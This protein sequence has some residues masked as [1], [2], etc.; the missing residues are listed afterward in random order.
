MG[1]HMGGQASAVLTAPVTFLPV[2]L[3][4][5]DRGPGGDVLVVPIWSDVRPLRGAVGLLDWRLC[6]KISQMIREGRVSGA[7]GEK[8]LLVTGRVPWRRILGI[9]AGPSDVFGDGACRA[10]LGCAFD[11][12]HGIGAERV[13][14]AL[15]GRDLD[16]LKPDLAMRHLIES[17]ANS[18]AKGK[19]LRELTVIDVPVATKAMSEIARASTPE[20]GTDDIVIDWATDSQS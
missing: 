13:A 3:H 1:G 8:L 6:G 12:A 2:D 18:E 4:R 15:P 9:G 16:L 17:L 20:Q 5:W 10:I 7:A 19:W 11:A 14:I